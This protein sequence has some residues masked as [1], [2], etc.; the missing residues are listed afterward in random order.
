MLKLSKFP[1]KT[2]KSTPKVSDNAST[3]YLLQG[4]FIRQ[5]VAGVYSYLH[6]G[7]KVLDKIK[8]I[9]REELDKEGCVEM[10]MPSI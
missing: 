1:F 7:Q 6:Y 10:L 2:L 9:I 5:E 4:A 8:D 3:G